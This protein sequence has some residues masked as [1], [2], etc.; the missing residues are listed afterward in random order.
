[1]TWVASLYMT[2]HSRLYRVIR[3]CPNP[4]LSWPLLL[5]VRSL[6]H[7]QCETNSLV[8]STKTSKSLYHG[9]VVMLTWWDSWGIS[10]ERAWD[11]KTVR[12]HL[13]PYQASKYVLLSSS[14]KNT[15]N[16]MN[17]AGLT[18]LNN[19]ATEQAFLTKIAT[20][21]HDNCIVTA[22][23]YPLFILPTICLRCRLPATLGP[24]VLLEADSQVCAGSFGATLGSLS[25]GRCTDTNVAYLP[26]RGDRHRTL[27]AANF[28]KSPHGLHPPRDCA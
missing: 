2:P 15:K 6:I 8:H 21:T 20:R 13:I 9:C 3:V 19:L 4:N 17:A 10:R 14:S 11:R 12:S 25:L 16:L 22:C 27:S 28:F 23:E 18:S 1:M 26:R 5:P 7:P 24:W